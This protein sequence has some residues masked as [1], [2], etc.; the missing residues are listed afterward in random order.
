[1]SY[2]LTTPRD[3][4]SLCFMHLVQKYLDRIK[5]EWNSH[6]LRACRGSVCPSGYPDELYFLPEV[7]G[8]LLLLT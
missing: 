3:C 6:R 1:M 5:A 4:L 7:L 2:I 8:M